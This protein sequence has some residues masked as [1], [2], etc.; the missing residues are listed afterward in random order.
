MLI[1]F[2]EVSLSLT[3]IT[4]LVADTVRKHGRAIVIASEGLKLGE[5]GERK[6]AFGH[7]ALSS[8][9]ITV[10]QLVVNHLNEVGLPAQGLARGQ[11]PGTEQ[12]DAIFYASPVDIAEAYQVGKVAVSVAAGGKSGVMVTIRRASGPAYRSEYDTIPLSEVAGKDRPFPKS[13][14]AGSRVDVTDEF[15]RYA[16]PLLGEDPVAIPI[17]GGKLRFARLSPI[18]TKKKCPPYV[19]TG[20]R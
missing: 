17:V 1:L 6:D 5:P 8:A 10:A 19:A 7:A 2:A 11:V 14:I 16:T 4:D 20:Y 9:Q 18:F 3:E 13:W 12:R 15:I